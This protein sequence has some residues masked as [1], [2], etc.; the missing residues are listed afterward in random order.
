MAITL[1]VSPGSCSRIPTIVLEEIG[2]PF[3]TQLVRF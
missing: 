2:Q 1:Y 3:D